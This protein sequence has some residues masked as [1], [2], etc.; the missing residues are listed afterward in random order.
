MIATL[1]YVPLF[2]Q[3]VLHGTPTEAGTAITPMVIS[4][5]VAS[6][7]AGRLIPTLGFRPLIRFGLGVTAAAGV[8]LALFGETHGLIGLRVITGAFGFGMGFANTALLIAVQTSVTWEQRGIATASTMFFRTIG[9]T[10][11]VGVMGGV[12]NASLMADASIPEDAASRVLSRDGAASLTPDLYARLG[13]ALAHGLGTVFWIIAGMGVVAFIT[14]IWFPHVPT[15]MNA[16]VPS[17]G[18]DLGH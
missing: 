2:V 16:P 12:I 10:L 7:I 11:A 1:T 15:Q 3:G 18:V 6:A 8:A 5:P 4:W 17:G 9:G 13:D 14:S